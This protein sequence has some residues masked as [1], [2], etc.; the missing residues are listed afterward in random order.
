MDGV[1]TEFIGTGF[2]DNTLFWTSLF[3]SVLYSLTVTELFNV[4][5]NTLFL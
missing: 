5:F 1:F 3:S 4:Y 2:V